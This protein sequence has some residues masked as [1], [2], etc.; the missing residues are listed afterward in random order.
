M[1][2]GFIGLGQ[3]GFPMAHR[4]LKEGFHLILF[5]LNL[6]PIL[7]LE[8]MGAKRG[9]NPAEVAST[10]EIV[11]SCLPTSQSVKQVYL[12]SDGLL[13]G[14]TEGEILVETGTISPILIRSIND[15]AKKRNIFIIDAGISGGPMGAENGTLTFIIGGEKQIVHRIRPILEIL[16]N[17][18]YYMG[19]SGNGVAAKLIN[20]LLSHINANA[21]IE[22]FALATKYGLDPKLL[23]EV[24]QDSSGNSRILKRFEN[25]ILSGSFNPG[26]SFELLYK[27]S[28]EACELGRQ[29]GVPMFVANAAHSVYE[30][31]RASGLKKENW[32]M[33]ITLWENLLKVKIRG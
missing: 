23:Y 13:D 11:I 32:G 28:Y 21:I 12:E 30:W 25:Y 26:M 9:K 4:L 2:L 17:K 18:I 10:A 3:M 31:G 8:R 33:L 22:G 16:G 29:L 27:D 14:A 20:N 15:I 7:K 19:D 6:D 1:E 24:I 5:D